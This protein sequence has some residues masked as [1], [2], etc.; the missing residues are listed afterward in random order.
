MPEEMQSTETNAVTESTQTSDSYINTDGTFKD[1]WTDHHI[2]AEIHNRN[3][4]LWSG[5]KSVNDLVNQI[6]N[7]DLTISRQG[8]GIFPPGENATQA[9]INAFHKALG[10]PDTPDGY[11]LTIPDEVKKYYQDQEQ[12]TE[13]RAELRKLGLTQKQFAGVMALDAARLQKAEQAMKADPMAFYEEALEL[14]MPLMKA[15]AEKTLRTKWGPA[16]DAR[17]QLANALI[18]ENTPEGDE[19]NQL[20][21]RIGNDP[22]VAD[23]L[24]TVQNKHHTESHGIDT[25]LGGGAKYMNVDQQVQAL[26]NNPHYLDGKT[27]P[28]EHRRLVDEVNRL[29]NQKSSGKMLE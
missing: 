12:L 28:A 6:H 13:A 11:T 29:L 22:L 9:E 1:G 27:N 21:E 15:E 26:M 14:A 16:F 7:Q 5:M 23:F 2:P 4:M 20:L 18:T 24:A 8:K 10:V 17:L 3:K 25:S 19:R